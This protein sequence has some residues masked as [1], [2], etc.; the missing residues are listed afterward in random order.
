MMQAEPLWTRRG[1][2]GSASGQTE[3]SSMRAIRVR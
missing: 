2:L 1:G 3:K